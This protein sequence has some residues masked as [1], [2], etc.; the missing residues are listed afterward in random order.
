MGSSASTEPNLKISGNN[1][2]LYRSWGEETLIGNVWLIFKT[3]SQNTNENNRRIR[4]HAMILIDIAGL[5]TDTHLIGSVA[6]LTSGGIDKVPFV[7]TD[8]RRE[9]EI[10]HLE[11]Y[12]YI[13]KIYNIGRI[14]DP[15]FWTLSIQ[16]AIQ[17][18]F[19]DFLSSLSPEKLW[20]SKINC[21]VF[22]SYILERLSLSWSKDID[23]PNGT[24]YLD[25]MKEAIES[26]SFLDSPN[27]SESWSDSMYS[28]G[29]YK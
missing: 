6:H 24:Y 27:I 8:H 5:S 7:R 11:S 13:G 1:N 17:D 19:K 14:E 22:A 12:H 16:K 21:H 23:P 18:W 2:H 29:K 15:D 25:L 26:V 3:Q 4:S 28:A 20:S 10:S 9:I